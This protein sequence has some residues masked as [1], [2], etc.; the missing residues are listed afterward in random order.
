VLADVVVSF[1]QIVPLIRLRLERFIRI[2]F[3][4][5]SNGLS[6]WDGTAT[7]LCHPCVH[8]YQQTLRSFR[9]AIRL[10]FSECNDGQIMNK[11]GRNGPCPCGSGKKYKKCCLPGDE[12]ARSRTVAEDREEPFIAELR[13]DVDEAVDRVLERIELGAGRAVEP[14]LKALLE[15]YP[16]YH[17]THF[18]MGVYIGMVG[19]DPIAAIP[20]F[21]KAVEIFPL[22]PEA[23]YNL[24][25]SARL[26]CDI[27]KAVKAL[28]AALRYSQGDDG[29]AEKARQ[30]LHFLETT[31]LKRSPFPNLDAYLAN[32]KLFDDGYVCLNQREFEKAIELFHRVLTDNPD[33]VQSFGNLALA[34]AGLGRRAAAM[35]CFE[36]ALAL[37]PGYEP[38][39]TNRRVVAQM[40]EGEPFSPSA[41]QET[42][43]Y[44][45]R[46]RREP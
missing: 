26:A 14:E 39:I 9:S 33:H 17:M 20:F 38:A 23:Q 18:A 25:T 5:P 1:R 30:E 19:K 12:A 45:D 8:G 41:I 35:E 22:F 3:R 34:Y 4:N 27:A 28:R 29:I 32:A 43:Y 6:Y 13:P 40:R 31:V 44:L 7:P 42:H 21:E 24:G 2:N 16:G 37:D 46:L 36:R 15:E 11:P 10:G